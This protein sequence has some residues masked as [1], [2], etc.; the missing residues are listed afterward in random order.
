[1]SF[2]NT[3]P[4]FLTFIAMIN[5]YCFFKFKIF[6]LSK[7]TI[8]YLKELIMWRGEYLM[9]YSPVIYDCAEFKRLPFRVM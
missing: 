5:P 6:V 9:L 4:C 3:A 7:V 2:Q 8:A 1:M